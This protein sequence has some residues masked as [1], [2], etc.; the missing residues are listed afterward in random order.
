M[1]V[2]AVLALALMYFYRENK[3]LRTEP[4][5]QTAS[6]SP[7]SDAPKKKVTFEENPV[8]K[9]EPTESE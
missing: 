6:V 5:S 9:N 7:V 1:I 4:A 2:I 8:E 3:K